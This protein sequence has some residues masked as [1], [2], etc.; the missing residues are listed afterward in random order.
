LR[1]RWDWSKA[2]N[3]MRAASLAG[4][5]MLGILDYSARWATTGPDGKG[6]YRPKSNADYAAYARAVAD[7]FRPGG[8]FWDE[9]PDLTPVALALEIWNEPFAYWSWGPEPDP[10]AYAATAR[11]AA[12]AIRSADPTIK[13]LISGDVAQFRRD[14]AA[15]DWLDKVL[16][17]DPG[18][19]ALIDAYSVHPYPFPRTK[20]PTDDS[21]DARSNYG[22]VPE[23]HSIAVAHGADHAIWI[24]EVG[25]T[26]ATRTTAGV[27]EANQAKYVRD[28]IE[29]AFT[30]WTFVDKVFVYAWDASNGDLTD[31]E[32]NFGLRRANDSLKPAWRSVTDAAARWRT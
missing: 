14:N 29:R 15:V 27:S 30:E 23:T 18:L 12:V 6:H 19:G 17:A 32:G 7:R 9:N 22:R 5:N 20:S 31:V 3:L 13:I 24:T 10:A 1:G 8:G 25:W 4:V 26:T 16:T 28:A 11:S 2:D 21:G